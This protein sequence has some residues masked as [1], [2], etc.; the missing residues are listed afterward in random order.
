[1]RPSAA[2]VFVFGG[3]AVLAVLPS[4]RPD[5]NAMILYA[6]LA[7]MALSLLWM[8]RRWLFW[9]PSRWLVTRAAYNTVVAERDAARASSGFRHRY[10]KADDALRATREQL[11]K[12]EERLREVE[13]GARQNS[14]REKLWLL[15]DVA[16]HWLKPGNAMRYLGP[17]DDEAAKAEYLSTYKRHLDAWDGMVRAIKVDTQGAED[18]W[19]KYEVLGNLEKGDPASDLIDRV[20]K[21]HGK[22]GKTVPRRSTSGSAYLASIDPGADSEVGRGVAPP[23]MAGRAPKDLGKLRYLNADWAGTLRTD[24]TIKVDGPLCPTDG[25]LLNIFNSARVLLENEIDATKV[26]R[27]EYLE[28]PK[29]HRHHNVSEGWLY[30]TPLEQ[31]A[32]PLAGGGTMIYL[33]LG[34]IRQKVRKTFSQKLYEPKQEALQGGGT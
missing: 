21:I 30:K 14:A 7:L 17:S 5:L 2:S 3:G 23:P 13:A 1:M 19:K 16:V 32:G 26:G 28:C 15:R 11:A 33:T 24:Q 12:S 22:L 20:E 25:S 6:G 29:C 4:L 9:L 8:L 31:I 34:E 10:E 27:S 18:E